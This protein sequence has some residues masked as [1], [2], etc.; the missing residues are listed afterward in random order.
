MKIYFRIVKKY[1]APRIYQFQSATSLTGDVRTG[2][3]IADLLTSDQRRKKENIS[4]RSH[5][6]SNNHSRL[7]N[8][9]VLSGV[10]Q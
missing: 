1:D 4:W 7:E 9:E 3:L 6:D 5:D 2:C 8:A 10:V